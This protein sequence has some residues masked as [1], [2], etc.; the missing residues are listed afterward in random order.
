MSGFANAWANSVD[1]ARSPPTGHN[2]S[3]RRS[4]DPPLEGPFAL[5]WGEDDLEW[6][7]WMLTWGDEDE[8]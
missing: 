3:P 2:V 5:A 7:G 8:V 1:V 6:A 4:F